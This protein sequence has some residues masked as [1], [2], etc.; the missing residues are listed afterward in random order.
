MGPDD[1]SEDEGTIGQDFLLVGHLYRGGASD[2]PADYDQ[3]DLWVNPTMDEQDSP[4]ASAMAEPD[5]FLATELLAI[6]MRAYNQE[7]DDEMLW[8]ELASAQRGRKWSIH[9]DCRRCG[10]GTRIR[11]MTLTSWTWCEFRL[12]AST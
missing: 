4:H 6:G 2:D 9:W 5:D 12:P 8:D 1:I 3:F 11:T 7:P 10:P